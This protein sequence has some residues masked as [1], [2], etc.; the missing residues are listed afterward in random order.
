MHDNN[1]LQQFVPG[2]SVVSDRVD[3]NKVVV[4]VG[5]VKLCLI[6]PRVNCVL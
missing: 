4:N 1:R 3:R 2:V 6:L 5:R